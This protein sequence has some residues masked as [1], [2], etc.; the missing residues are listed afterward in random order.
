MDQAELAAAFAQAQAQ[1]PQVDLAFVPF[2]QA[3]A[4]HAPLAE[5]LGEFYLAQ[6][7]LAG[8]PAAHQHF[9]RVFLAAALPPVRR[10]LRDDAQVEELLQL[11]RVRLLVGDGRPRLAEY[12]G[13]GSL[14]GWVKAVA[15]R[16]ALNQVATR[17]R[18][19]TREAPLEALTEVGLDQDP[20]LAMLQQAHRADF[21]A[22]L[23]AAWQQLTERQRAVL[24]MNTLERASID[25]IG[26]V[27]GVHRVTASRWVERA[28]GELLAGTR[29]VLAARLKLSTNELES[30]L[31]AIDSK[32][33]I[34]LRSIM[35]P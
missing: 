3:C 18:A 28:R 30:L 10:V 9:E 1:W 14:Q 5:H 25:V 32:L 6:G 20:T 7:C 22:A 16:L 33:E 8:S 15:I 13:Q 2:A 29:D 27:Y 31:R 11:T 21:R 26:A 12:K 4:R 34:S 24:R 17:N 35:R 19:E 23:E